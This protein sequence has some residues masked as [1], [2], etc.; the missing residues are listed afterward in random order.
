MSIW[1][2]Y[3]DQC[4]VGFAIAIRYITMKLAVCDGSVPETLKKI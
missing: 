3:T 2:Y 4:F 1:Q